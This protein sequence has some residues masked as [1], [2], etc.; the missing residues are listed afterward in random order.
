MWDALQDVARTITLVLEKGSESRKKCPRCRGSGLLE[1][2]FT[3]LE[4]NEACQN[5][6]CWFCEGVGALPIAGLN[7]FVLA[8]TTACLKALNEHKPCVKFSQLHCRYGEEKPKFTKVKLDVNLADLLFDFSSSHWIGSQNDLSNCTSHSLDCKPDAHEKSRTKESIIQP[9]GW[10]RIL[11]LQSSFSFMPP[12]LRSKSVESI[13]NAPPDPSAGNNLQPNASLSLPPL[14]SG[15]QPNAVLVMPAIKNTVNIHPVHEKLRGGFAKRVSYIRNTSYVHVSA[16]RNQQ[17]DTELTGQFIPKSQTRATA[18]VLSTKRRRPL[19]KTRNCI[20]EKARKD[21]LERARGILQTLRFHEE[22][23]STNFYKQP[24][25][26][27]GTS[28]SLQ[29]KGPLGEQFSPSVAA[30]KVTRLTSVAVSRQSRYNRLIAG[31]VKAL[32]PISRSTR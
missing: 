14:V 15:L 12:I 13:L 20:R 27:E 17:A 25:G 16:T 5:Q 11:Q 22:Q 28:R 10:E 32:M 9:H 31:K 21:A 19:R 18:C 23:V 2:A 7:G 1:N 24:E 6:P 8:R 29:G 3:R 30:P 4:K 26:G